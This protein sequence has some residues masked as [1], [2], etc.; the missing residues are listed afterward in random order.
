MLYLLEERHDD[1]K[2]CDDLGQQLLLGLEAS[3]CFMMVYRRDNCGIRRY[4]SSIVLVLLLALEGVG[5]A[6][7]TDF[8]QVV[9]LDQEEGSPTVTRGKI[10][11]EGAVAYLYGFSILIA[12]GKEGFG[13]TSWTKEQPKMCSS[14]RASLESTRDY[15]ENCTN[16]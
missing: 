12:E 1:Y 7:G 8:V 3:F 2:R 6:L 14:A 16:S 10:K 9:V 4:R 15:I 11:K 5:C 13:G